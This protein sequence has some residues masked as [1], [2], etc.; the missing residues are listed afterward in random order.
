MRVLTED[1]RIARDLRIFRKLEVVR[2]YRYIL[3][4]EFFLKIPTLL[5]IDQSKVAEIKLPFSF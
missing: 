3:L 2:F 5:V 1:E 4:V